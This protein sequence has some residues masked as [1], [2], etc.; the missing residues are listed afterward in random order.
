MSKFPD[1]IINDSWVL[2]RRGKKN[3][4][5]AQKP[6]AWMIEKELSSSGRIEDVAIIFLTNNECPFRCLMCDLWKNTTD[7]RVMAGSIPHQIELALNE[8]PAAM[9]LKLYNSG[10]FFD[11]N[12]IP[13]EDY[14]NIA[15]MVN[16][17][18]TVIVESHPKMIGTKCLNFR[19]L[20]KT[21]LNV[22]LGLETVHTELLDKLNK[23]MTLK[24]FSRAVKFL[25]RNEILSRAFVL[26][27]PP[28]LSEEE[29]ILW[30]EKSIE[31]AFSEGIEC[32]TVIPVRPGNGAMDEL[33]E[34]GYF[35]PPG[36]SSLEK[37]LEYGINLKAGRVFAD[38]WDLK[39][40]SGCD[41]CI[42][43][44]TSRIIEM[45]L[46]QKIYPSVKCSCK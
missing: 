34:K 24:D 13:V 46:S 30:A 11:P 21:D 37:V 26:L 28:F 41:E 39:L 3:P 4:V 27:K 12:A 15:S 29:G 23:K 38:T 35:D 31:F 1:L 17:F 36:I 19:D 9:H 40:F 16:S 5:D 18:K 45:N 25:T 44:R 6:C 43:E 42:D 32:C 20:L 14:A 7:K 10:S 33:M 22:A 8:L 2:S